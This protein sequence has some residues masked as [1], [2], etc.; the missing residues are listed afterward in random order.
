MG[1][2]ELNGLAGVV[3]RAADEI[4]TYRDGV[5]E[6]PVA[7]QVDVDELRRAFGTDVPEG[8]TAPDEVVAALVKATEPGLVASVGPRYFGFVT[9]GSLEAAT[10]A[11]LMASGWDQNAFTEVMS[12]AAIAAEHVA[13]RWAKEVLGIPQTASVGFVTGAQETNTV[14]IA[15]GRHHVL[16]QNG[17]DVV[18]DGLHGAPPVRVVASEERHA[19]VDRSLR[20]LGLGNNA[21]V[22]VRAESNGAIDV[23]HLA[24][25]LAAEPEAPTIVCLQS[26]NVNTG[27][28]DDLATAVP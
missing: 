21:I 27:A 8:P 2:D 1:R 14:G 17:W 26:G 12:P 11:D 18:Q 22:P 13:G 7:R 23:G 28:C 5:A 20:L 4:L 19:T 10:G 16:E 6:R 9:G 24:E 3:S 15:A 25:V